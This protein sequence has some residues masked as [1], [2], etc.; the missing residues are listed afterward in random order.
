MS[1]ERVISPRETAFRTA[2]RGI[3]RVCDSVPFTWRITVCG[4]QQLGQLAHLLPALLIGAPD[5]LGIAQVS[6]RDG[7][8]DRLLRQFLRLGIGAGDMENETRIRHK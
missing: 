6:V 4:R 8:L 7:G 1:C 2:C 5:E 3:S